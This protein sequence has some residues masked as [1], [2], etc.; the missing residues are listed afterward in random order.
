MHNIRVR[1]YPDV[2]CRRTSL[3]RSKFYVSASRNPSAVYFNQVNRIQDENFICFCLEYSEEAK[4]VLLL[5]FRQAPSRAYEVITMPVL[6][7][8]NR[9]FDCT[10]FSELTL[11]IILRKE[12]VQL[13][14]CILLKL[15]DL[16][17]ITF[18]AV[19]AGHVLGFPF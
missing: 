12:T 15:S 13:E 3:K 7:T 14:E 18:E 5:S 19:S 17:K 2:R 11:F 1:G 8:A 4:R 16:T 9:V 10:T 6:D